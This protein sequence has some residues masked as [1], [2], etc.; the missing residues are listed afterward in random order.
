M[1]EGGYVGL[2]VSMVLLI[3]F[4]LLGY[5]AVLSIIL[6]TVGGVAAGLIVKFLKNKEVSA[7]AKKEDSEK[8][9]TKRSHPLTRLGL[10][11]LRFGKSREPE[12]P[13]EETRGRWVKKRRRKFTFRR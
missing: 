8:E 6:G 7:E 1:G 10:Q 4:F 5:S 13:P 11:N 12:L 9:E 3:I 2:Q